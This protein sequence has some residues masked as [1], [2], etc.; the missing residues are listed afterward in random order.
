MNK[1]FNNKYI[2]ILSF[3]FLIVFIV[4][5]FMNIKRESF[6]NNNIEIV[7]AR[8]NE[9]LQWLKSDPFNRYNYIVYNKGINDNFLKSEKFKNEIKLNNI[10]RETH[11]YLTHIIN[12]YDG[13]LAEF[14]LFV[15]GSL[16][17]ENRNERAKRLF[18]AAGNDNKSDLFA[19]VLYDNSVKDTFNDFQIDKYL[20]SNENNK[21]LNNDDTMKLSDIR[22][23]GKWYE[24][25]F[26]NVNNDSKCFTQ[27]SMFGLTRD[28]ILKKPKTYYMNLIKQVKEHNNHETVHYF[29]RSWETV[30]FP[31]S[32]V[33]H[34]Y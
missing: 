26:N 33:K 19:C 24:T 12:N 21:S 25:I 8:Y 4:F 28:T 7:I 17:L 9:D 3:I 18:I 11:T 15:P 6:D 10:G 1:L 34:I 2:I 22:P 29:E 16:E 13:G 14:T 23:Y 31:Y 20:S 32:D 5:K 27:N 30:F